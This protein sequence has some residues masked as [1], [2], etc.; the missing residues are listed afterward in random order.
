MPPFT[1]FSDVSLQEMAYYFP[2]DKD[3]FSHITGVGAWKL[4]QFGDSF[5]ESIE[6]F[7]VRNQD[8]VRPAL[9]FNTRKKSLL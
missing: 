4:E 9:G 6:Q 8:V 2:Q 7:L 1:V 5:L 3:A